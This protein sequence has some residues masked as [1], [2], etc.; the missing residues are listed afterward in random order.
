MEVIEPVDIRLSND[1][2]SLEI[3]WT[4]GHVT[5]T[6]L[7]TLRWNCPCAICSGEMGSKGLLSQVKELPDDEYILEGVQPVGRYA[8][9]LVWKSG[10]DSGIYTYELL[11]DLCQCPEHA[12]S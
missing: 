9:Q 3:E 1:G 5:T 7:R 6:D 12:T 10:H 11:R 8:L 2:K 4:D